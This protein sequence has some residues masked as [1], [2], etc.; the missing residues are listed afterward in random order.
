MRDS[1]YVL[2]GL[3]YHESDL[4]IKEHFTDTAGFTD[5]VFGMTH[6]LGFRFAPRIRDLDDKNIFTPRKNMEK[7][8]PKLATQ[9]GG[10]INFQLIKEHWEDIIRLT[11]SIREGTVTAS[12]MLRK[13]SSYPR[14][15]GLALALRELGRI[16]RSLLILD[17]MSDPQLRRRATR[18][19]N[20]GESRHAL[21]KAVHFYQ[22][23]E[24]RERKLLQQEHKMSGLNL[25]TAAIIYWNTVE[26]DK[27]IT[28]M[29]EAGEEVNDELLQYLSPLNWGHINL[30]GYYVW[31]GSKSTQ[32]L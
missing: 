5:Q 31:R 19:L 30:T 9:L 1:T 11:L 12:L 13:L 18:E 2:D 17:W 27:I 6:L 16:E 20:K 3:L 15:N 23:G 24:I 4:D 32:N 14:Q 7:E 8:L 28:K 25:V 10:S 22:Q 26:I 29:R 21:A